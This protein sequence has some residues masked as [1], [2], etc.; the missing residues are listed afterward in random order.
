MSKKNQDGNGS[1]KTFKQLIYNV[2]T[3]RQTDRDAMMK[4][5]VKIQRKLSILKAIL[6]KTTSG[7]LEKYIASMNAILDRVM[8]YDKATLLDCTH[9][10]MTNTGASQDNGATTKTTPT[11]THNY[12][13]LTDE[14]LYKNAALTDKDFY[15]LYQLAELLPRWQRNLAISATVSVAAAGVMLLVIVII[16]TAITI[17]LSTIIPLLIIFPIVAALAAFAIAAYGT[18][19]LSENSMKRS[20]FAQCGTGERSAT[21]NNP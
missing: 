5:L 17:H 21:G 4:R 13:A 1:P 6:A 7:T 20:I 2:I 15:S 3:D 16:A 19:S 10:F 12:A 8:G 18:Q 9:H 14:E 11:S